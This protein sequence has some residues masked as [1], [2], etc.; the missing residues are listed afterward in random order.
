MKSIHRRLP[1]AHAQELRT[2]T[3]HKYIRVMLVA[4][5]ALSSL[6]SPDLFVL[7][8]GGDDAARIEPFHVAKSACSVGPYDGCRGSGDAAPQLHHRHVRCTDV[9]LSGHLGLIKDRERLPAPLS[10]Q[11]SPAPVAT[12]DSREA[13]RPVAI[14]GEVRIFNLSNHPPGI[15]LQS[16]VL[17]I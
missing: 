1:F 12:G 4:L 5:F 16:V 17:L 8:T 2:W 6:A 11:S 14:C 7:C 13:G 9:G 10:L 3:G 15:D